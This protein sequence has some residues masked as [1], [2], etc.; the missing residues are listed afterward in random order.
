MNVWLQTKAWSEAT[1]R[2]V[3]ATKHVPY[4]TGWKRTWIGATLSITMILFYGAL[5]AAVAIAVPINNWFG[6]FHGV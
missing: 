3:K 1:A 2:A 4:G 5:L 6:Q